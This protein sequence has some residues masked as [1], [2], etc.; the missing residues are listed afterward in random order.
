M[1]PFD[2][3]AAL[4]QLQSGKQLAG[5]DGILI[6]LSG[7]VDTVGVLNLTPSSPKPKAAFPMKTACLNYS[8]SAFKTPAP[9]GQCRYRTGI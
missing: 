4:K 8:T 1:E 6:C 5:K 3:N 9:N 2:F 7:D